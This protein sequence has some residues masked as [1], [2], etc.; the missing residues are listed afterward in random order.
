MHYHYKGD[1]YCE[2]CLPVGRA[3][4][5]VSVDYGEQDVPAHCHDCNRPLDYTLTPE[6]VA[7]VVKTLSAALAKGLDST[8][9]TTG[10]YEGSPHYAIVYDWADALDGYDLSDGERAVVEK[11]MAECERLDAET[12]KADAGLWRPWRLQTSRKNNG[13]RIWRIIDSSDQLVAEMPRG[14]SEPPTD[15]CDS[16]AQCVI[17]CVNAHEGLLAALH[18]LLWH[19]R[20]NCSWEPDTKPE[21]NFAKGCAAIDQ[22]KAAIAKAEGRAD[23]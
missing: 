9:S 1:E 19:L 11:Y 18:G 15:H 20:E 6:G 23:V 12:G 4:A 3:S 16:R 22:A 13:T 2:G 17:L 5:G 10:D 7:Y 8:P 14:S 21:A